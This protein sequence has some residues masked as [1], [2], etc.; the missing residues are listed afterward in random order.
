MEEWDKIAGNFDVTRRFPW[1]ECI[2]FIDKIKGICLDI[3]C[4][5]GRHLIPAAEKCRL[6]IGFDISIK[7]LEVARKNLGEK[8]MRNVMLVR[9][10]A[11]RLPF[12]DDFFDGILFIAAL[13][14]IKG[15]DGRIKA[16]EEVKRVLKPDGRAL[17]SVWSKWQERWR[18]YFILHP[19]KGDIYVPW[20]R[21]VEVK[22]FYHLYSMRELKRDAKKAGLKIERAWSVKKASRKYADNHFIVV[23][24]MD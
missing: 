4:G 18:R 12:P 8:G 24:K 20:R 15:R 7:M 21:G 9:G 13:H 22:R 3:G 23:K 16:L 1:K 11:R 17:I 6:A 5:N 19:F 2:E 14:N 10:D